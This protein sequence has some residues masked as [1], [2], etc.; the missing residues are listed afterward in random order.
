MGEPMTCVFSHGK[1]SGPWGAKIERLA[2][3]A[4]AKGFAV[5]SVDYREIPDPELRVERL[6][7]VCAGIATPIVLVGSSMGGYVS[8]VASERVRPLALFLDLTGQ[9]IRKTLLRHVYTRWISMR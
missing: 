9:D 1:E 5:E 7:E 6:V 2:E 4:R 3:V 8:T